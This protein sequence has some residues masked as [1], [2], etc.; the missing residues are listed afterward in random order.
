MYGRKYMGVER[1][2]FVLDEKG[3]IKKIFN[4]VKVDGHDKEVLE[5]LKD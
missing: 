3:R 1:T 4:K 5:A 2:T